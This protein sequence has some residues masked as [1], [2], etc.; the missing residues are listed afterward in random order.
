MSAAEKAETPSVSN[1]SKNEFKDTP[2]VEVVI[3]IPRGSFL[4]RGSTGELDFISPLPCPFN[5]GSVPAFIG[6]EG[7]LLDA[8][9]LGPRLPA[10]KKVKVYA[11]GSIGLTDRGLY[12]DKLICSQVPISQWKRQ[13]ILIF[14]KIYSKAKSFLNMTRGRKGVNHCE[15]WDNAENALARA[16]PRTHDNWQGPT[17]PF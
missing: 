14:F 15:G 10:G 12:D 2:L 16:T 11:R 8:V 13:L 5:Y 4:K 17:I 7:D 9:V 6:L 3:E 1:D